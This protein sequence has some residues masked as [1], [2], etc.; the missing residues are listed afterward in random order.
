MDLVAVE[1][2]IP[3]FY[4]YGESNRESLAELF[5]SL[6]VKVIMVLNYVTAR[7]QILTYKTCFTNNLS[8]IQV[9]ISNPTY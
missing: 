4:N 3:S 6:L 8:A 7:I 2:I 1:K 5:V 9:F